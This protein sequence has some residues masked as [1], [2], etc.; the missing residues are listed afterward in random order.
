M[1]RHHH[2]DAAVDTHTHRH[3]RTHTQRNQLTGKNTHPRRQFCVGDTAPLEPQGGR[4]RRPNHLRRNSIGNRTSRNHNPGTHRTIHQAG[5]FGRIQERRIADRDGRIG[6]QCTEQ[7]HEPVGQIA[8]RRLVE[9]IR[10][11]GDRTRPRVTGVGRCHHHPQIKLR[12]DQRR[13]HRR[14]LQPGQGHLRTGYRRPRIERQHHLCERCERLTAH[15]IDRLDD[16]FERNVGMIERVEI[17]DAYPIEQ[18]RERHRGLDGGPQHEGVDEHADQRIEHGLTTPGDRGGH[19]DVVGRGHPGQQ[20][21]ECRVYHH[22]RRDIATA[23]DPRHAVGD[24]GGDRELQ[25]RTPIRRDLRTRPVG[26]QFQHVG[27]TGELL[28]PVSELTRRDRLG[29][30]DGAERLVLPD[31]EVRELDLQRCPLRRIT[32]RP[33][34]VGGDDIGHQRQHRLAVGTDVV[35]HHTE[36]VIARNARTQGDADRPARRD[37]ESGRHRG[38]QIVVGVDG[39]PDTARVEQRDVVDPLVRQAVGDREGGAQHLVSFDGV[40]HRL[41]QG[42]HVE[43]TGQ[44]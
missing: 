38:E 2:L 15:R 9:Q 4:I 8:D 42:R 32:L 7:S 30:V 41:P 10:R 20:R 35:Q 14:D 6:D 29:V 17:I 16:G 19:R 33:C 5:P 22:E 11:I 44:P 39:L 24:I 27:Q 23:R 26:G 13:L 1:N 12:G 18:L 34:S 37:V 28:T 25:I 36:Q 43:I 3:I 40:D 21:R 31:R